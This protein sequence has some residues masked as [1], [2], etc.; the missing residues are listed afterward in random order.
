MKGVLKQLVILL[1]MPT[2]LAFICNHFSPRGIPIIGQWDIE[3]GVVRAMSNHEAR[4]PDL[5][6]DSVEEAKAIFDSDQ[7]VF[8]DA[9]S[10]ESYLSGHIPGS[11]HLQPYSGTQKMAEFKDK[12]EEDTLIV[13]YC[14]GRECEDS[15][16]LAERFMDEGFFEVRVF[17]D[18]FPAWESKGYPTER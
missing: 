16:L 15:H 4:I 3:K 2:T 10:E 1:I 5:E 6:I 13:T 9:R 7:A 8:V 11:I 12:V 17:I 14:S 18:G